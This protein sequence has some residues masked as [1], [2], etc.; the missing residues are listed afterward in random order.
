MWVVV[1]TKNVGVLYLWH[2]ASKHLR[3][4]R[5]PPRSNQELR[6]SG[7]AKIATTRCVITQ[8]SAIFSYFAVA[9][10][11]HANF[12]HLDG[13]SI[14]RLHSWF[15]STRRI[16]NTNTHE[17]NS[18]NYNKSQVIYYHLDLCGAVTVYCNPLGT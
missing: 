10:S 13:T 4:L 3:D 11:N 5:V 9:P 14:T 16:I 7:S 18:T 12:F 2:L 1:H 15:A 8:N 17:T 6:S